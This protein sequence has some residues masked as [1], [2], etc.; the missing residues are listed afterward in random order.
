MKILVCFKVGPDLEQVADSDWAGFGPGTDLAYAGQTLGCFDESALEMA[1][2]LKS[3]CLAEGL[4]A[5]C[6]ALTV[7][8]NPPAAVWQTLYAAGFDCVAAAETA[9]GKLEFQPVQ[10]AGVLAGYARD[11]AFDLILTGRQTGLGDTASVPF[12]LAEA[13][14]MPVLGEA[15]LVEL[16]PPHLAV[17][18][19]TR[20]GRE[21]LTVRPPLTVAIGNSPVSAL[22][23]VT[24][25]SKL[26]AAKRRVEVF[27][28]MGLTG[29][30]GGPILGWEPA[31]ARCIFWAADSPAELAARVANE[32]MGEVRPWMPLL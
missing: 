18:L 11:R 21:R 17:T 7:G 12:L 26:A 1:L 8:Q 16:R 25:R 27:P 24:L 30:C 22:R 31:D 10:V 5:H 32:L 14:G 4:D 3:A 29:E 6:T 20:L 23:A 28:V 2:R 9:G 19:A 15:E 13:L